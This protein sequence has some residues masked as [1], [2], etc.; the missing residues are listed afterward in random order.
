MLGFP[1]QGTRYNLKNNNNMNNLGV[2]YFIFIQIKRRL[3]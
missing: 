2:T 1:K 3:D